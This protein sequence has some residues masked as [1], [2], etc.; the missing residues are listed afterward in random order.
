MLCHLKVPTESG[1]RATFTEANSTRVLT[2]SFQY[3]K[4]QVD[5]LILD[6]S[7]A[8]DRVPHQ[9]LLYKLSHYDI[10]G[11]LLSW[12]QV[13]LTKRTQEVTLEGVLSIQCFVT[14]G[15]PHGT[16]LGPLLFLVYIND[17]PLC[18][19]S[20]MRLFADDCFL[21]RSINSSADCEVV[22]KDLDAL[23]KWERVRQM[24]FNVEKC[25]TICFSAKKTNL[26]ATYVLNNHTL[27]RVHRHSY[28]LCYTL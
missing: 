3:V 10:Q 21:Y 12:I 25:H 22:Q 28:V 19:S 5:A 27:T 13:F 1:D 16:V 4:K 17:L 9:R 15:V 20:T 26:D 23:V 11:S 2:K 7:K 24:S 8:F 6:F 14:S 18:I